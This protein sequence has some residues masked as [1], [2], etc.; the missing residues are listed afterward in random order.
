MI[1]VQ[2]APKDKHGMPILPELQ[3]QYFL[4]MMIAGV[5]MKNSMS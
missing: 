5:L 3:S 1:E 4:L 2:N